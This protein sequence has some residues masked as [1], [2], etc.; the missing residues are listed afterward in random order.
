MHA[1]VK[2]VEPLVM[3]APLIAVGLLIAVGISFRRPTA[4]GVRWLW[5]SLTVLYCLAASSPLAAWLASTLESP[6]YGASIVAKPPTAA[7]IVVLAGGA[8]VSGWHG[9]ES[10][11]A[12]ASWRRLWR[13]VEV[14]IASGAA[15][16]IVYTGRPVRA[17]AGGLT[18]SALARQA[19][20][21]WGVPADRFWLEEDAR[22]TY[23]SA[24]D[25][26]K[27]L[28]ERGVTGPII[29]VTSAWHLP[30][31]VASFTKQ[32]LTVVP[33]P[34]DFRGGQFSLAGWTPSYEALSLTSVSVREWIALASYKIRGRA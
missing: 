10:E 3:P 21:R 32:G 20:M 30:R 23:E 22:D 14:H 8:D 26:K 6:Y 16:P 27:L 31:A 5:L 25:V 4:R 2:F 13:G 15:L 12:G 29:L 7:A 19:A 18:E 1:F 34:C 33:E 28:A 9:R 24:V 11:L 17:M